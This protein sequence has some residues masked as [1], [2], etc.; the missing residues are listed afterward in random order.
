MKTCSIIIGLSLIV[1]ISLGFIASQQ[2]QAVEDDPRVVLETNQGDITVELFMDVCPV[3]AGNFMNLSKDGFYDG[4]IFHRV[5]PDFMIQ[6]G[7]PTGT[8]SGGPG[9]AIDDEASAL[10][11]HHGYGAVSMANSGPDTGGSQFFIVVNLAGS[12]HLDGLHAVFGQVVEGMDV[13]VAISEVPRDSNNKPHDDVII[14]KVAIPD[15]EAP[16]V[17]LKERIE[18]TK[19]STVTLDGSGSTDD[20]GI[21]NW[22]WAV[23]DGGVV[24]YLYGSVQDFKFEDV[25]RHDVVLTVRDADGNT[26][27]ERVIVTVRSE[28]EESPGFLGIM[29]LLTLGIVS[30]HLVRLRR[31]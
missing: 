28:E 12:G 31:R 23:P 20:V 14:E 18:T 13:A 9:Y 4:I 16:V 5:L 25:G 8:G 15:H 7:D 24:I 11:L 6:G 26:A 2:V 22:T 27:S 21:V 29:S 10:S 30:M 17:V 3:T 19:G 1:L